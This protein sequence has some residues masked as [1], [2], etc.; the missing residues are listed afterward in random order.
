MATC[1]DA[2]RASC[3]KALIQEPQAVQYRCGHCTRV[4]CALQHTQ[5]RTLTNAGVSYRALGKAMMGKHVEFA[6][7]QDD[8]SVAWV[9]GTVVVSRT[10]CCH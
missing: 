1:G 5:S 7:H 4:T 10:A 3:E 2:M 6:R 9:L 8:E